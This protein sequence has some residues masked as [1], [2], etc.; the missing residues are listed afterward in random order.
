MQTWSEPLARKGKLG[1]LARLLGS[2]EIVCVQEVH[3]V[4]EEFVA[5]HVSH[6]QLRLTL[7]VWP[8]LSEIWLLT[9]ESLVSLK[10]L[11]LA[12]FLGSIF[13]A[14]LIGEIMLDR[15]F[16]FI[17]MGLVNVEPL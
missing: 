15:S 3:G 14:G 17:L 7:E 9:Q 11:C 2:H 10:S 4:G 13:P 8:F 5:T 1:E 16:V 6:L 12:E